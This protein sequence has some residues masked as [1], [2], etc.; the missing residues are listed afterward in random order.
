MDNPQGGRYESGKVAAM[1]PR[2]GS[3]V[4]TLGSRLGPAGDG[5]LLDLLRLATARLPQPT[6]AERAAR[7][8]ASH[9]TTVAVRWLQ[10]GQWVTLSTAGPAAVAAQV[11]EPPALLELLAD[12][13]PVMAS[14]L[15]LQPDEHGEDPW[16]RTLAAGGVRVALVLPLAGHGQLAGLVGLFSARLDPW[17]EVSFERWQLLAQTLWEALRGDPSTLAPLPTAATAGL[18]E[19]LVALHLDR[20]PEDLCRRAVAHLRGLLEADWVTVARWD[21]T[22]RAYDC[23]QTVDRYLLTT[24]ESALLAQAKGAPYR[25]R[26]LPV[27][28]GDLLAERLLAASVQ[29]VVTVPLL[30][31][32]DDY[33]TLVLGY[34]APEAAELAERQSL[35][36]QLAF[37]IA[38]A[39]RDAGLQEAQE[40][41]LARLRHA[42]AE[43]TTGAKF[44]ALA[45]MAGG[46]A[47][48]FNN[49][50]GGILARAQLLQR[51]TED[52]A[53]LK[54]LTTISE[55][56]WRAAQTVRRLQEFTRERSEDD[57][58]PVDAPVLWQ[59]LADAARQQVAGFSRASGARYHIEL[60]L[61]TFHGQVQA[62]VDELVEA[63]GNVLTNALEASP[64]GGIV[65]LHGNTAGGELILTV[66]DRG[67]G[68]SA[69]EQQ[70]CFDPFYS[71]KAETGVGLGLSVT[72]GIISRHRGEVTIESAPDHGTTVTITLPLL[73]DQTE[74]RQ[75][76]PHVLVI[77]DEEALCEVLSEL[78]TIAGY[79]CETCAGGREGIERFQNT[80]F[81][82]VC[83]DLRT[84]DLSG[85]EVIRAVKESGRGT[86][87]MLL[88]GFREQLQPDQ[89]AASG[90][91]MVLGKPFTLQ[92]VL[93]AGEKLLGP[94]ER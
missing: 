89:I 47:H 67:R 34:C 8:L 57:F 20:D 70:S 51:Q 7:L 17:V 87:V 90:V 18:R 64:G 2:I 84:E 9:E 26:S 15:R 92:Q 85:W 30:F 12:G 71:T 40:H 5:V 14:D 59:R 65:T 58:Q 78:F 25:A 13:K 80:H 37:H 54:G 3:D 83:T 50:L 69:E 55:I 88:T 63:V 60:E 16:Q 23:H 36:E 44:K 76:V 27:V 21:P 10:A 56:G 4:A 1:E 45:Q 19:A 35:A 43:A 62:N 68:M 49:A 46:V 72:Y 91:D 28:P 33:G 29:Q 11:P 52:R 6:A 75:A 32:G 41:S 39:L 53:V 77:D 31:Q 42:Q 82:L 86:P 22:Q 73:A 38:L 81:D 74:P 66:V 94:Q 61:D 24:A 79:T 48:E 93:A